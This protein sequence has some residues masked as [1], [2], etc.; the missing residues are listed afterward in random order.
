VLVCAP[1]HSIA[2]PP[3]GLAY[4]VSY[5]RE[6]GIE[7][8]ARD[9]NIEARAHLLDRLPTC[10]V[11]TNARRLVDELFSVSRRTYLAEAAAWSWLDPGGAG[12]LVERTLTYRFEPLRAFWTEVGIEQLT[13]DDELTLAIDVLRMFLESEAQAL[14][15]TPDGWV[16][17]STTITNLAA[18]LFLAQRI[19]AIN[20]DVYLVVGGAHVTPRSAGP[21]LRAAPF[22]D[23][24]VPMPS[25]EPL[26][27]VV[28]DLERARRGPVQPG[29]WRTRRSGRARLHLGEASDVAIE[30]DPATTPTS[31]DELPVADWTWADLQRHESG[32][33]LR[34]RARDAARWYP[35]VPIQTSRGCSF[36][37]C[38]FCHN[39]TD[40]TKY[41]MQEPGRV[42]REVKHQIE[43]VRSRGFF[44]TD[45]EFTGSRRRTLQIC[46]AL[47]ALDEDIRFFCWA[48][49]DKLDAE[50]LERMYA[51]GLRQLFVGV[52][53]IDDHL[54]S[55]MDKG[56][57][58]KSALRQLRMLHEFGARHPEFLYCFNLIID[59][60]GE[61]LEDVQRTFE[62]VA[63][64]PE[65]FCGHLAACCVF[66]LYEGTPAFAQMHL[67]SAGCI[68]PLTPSDV[69]VPALRYFFKRRNEASRPDRVEVWSAIAEATRVGGPREEALSRSMLAIYD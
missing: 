31:M 47:D 29:I 26:A 39:V 10:G 8:G 61:R 13:S 65:L 53:A 34:S 62:M 16:G 9:L 44:F 48:R 68:E 35:T 18:T 6:G 67:G 58:G 27:R 3:V 45:D 21:L 57:D 32:F 24:A 20:P 38:K 30:C 41:T 60:P 23:A 28:A 22:L 55:L 12:A 17:F 11:P 63:D 54:L 25:F 56:Y 19:R 50:L 42:A 37:R 66:H 69:R 1:F 51:S 49:L 7:T 4:L 14:A 59:Y 36:G 40:Y 43:T 15:A 52:E 2:N 33:T 5:L 64:E 46:D